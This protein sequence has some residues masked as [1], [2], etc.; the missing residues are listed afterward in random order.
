MN[1]VIAQ[2][3]SQVDE[4]LRSGVAWWLAELAEMLPLRPKGPA[5]RAPVALEM[6]EQ[7]LSLRVLGARGGPPASVSIDPD[8]PDGAQTAV[9]TALTQ[10]GRGSGVTIE[11]L[12]DQ[13]LEVALSLP[14][15]A[16]RTMRQILQNQL[17]R[18][19]PLPP[20]TVEF[21]Y[22][23]APRKG[24]EETLKVTVTVV[25]KATVERALKVAQDLRL[26]PQKII[27]RG[28][29]DQAPAVLWRA[30]SAS[31]ESAWHR[32]VRHFL[33]LGTLGLLVGAF[34]FYV[35]RLDQQIQSLDATMGDKARLAKAAMQL[36]EQRNETE[37][38]LDLVDK[39]RAVPTP[40]QILNEV[41]KLLPDD[42]WVSRMQVQGQTIEIFG[43]SRNV[44]TLV[45][46]LS[47][48]PLFGDPSFLSPITAATGGEA[49][50]FHLSIDILA[51]P[52][53]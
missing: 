7:R 19:V 28:Q 17:Y 43:A 46:I 39:R 42:S 3:R 48:A 20:E 53:P 12:P 9:R 26:Q 40:L 24:A 23:I 33:E 11:L 30:E 32:H 37:T 10:A 5:Q 47:K 36:A 45:N 13:V 49:Q 1:G 44:S 6:G 38:A 27:A 18:M 16:E 41:T 4:S 31:D 29:G 21:A 34:A 25:P 8:M 15:G 22:A 14:R 52:E 2:W 51:A 35:V 50:Q